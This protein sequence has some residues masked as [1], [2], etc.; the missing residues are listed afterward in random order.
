MV[1][2]GE[3]GNCSG[4]SARTQQ[5]AGTSCRRPANVPE[6]ND[7]GDDA[8]QVL[9]DATARGE[10]A[11]RSLARAEALIVRAAQRIHE[12][13]FLLTKHPASGKPPRVQ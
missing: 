5:L 6:N 3:A 7:D 11:Q 9:Q 12:A 8:A 4:S 13:M 10:R 2:T 1:V